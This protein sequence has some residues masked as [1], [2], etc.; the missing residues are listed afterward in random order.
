MQTGDSFGPFVNHN[1]FA[2]WMLMALRSC[3]CITKDGS[4]R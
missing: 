3:P 4:Q 1:H 2:G